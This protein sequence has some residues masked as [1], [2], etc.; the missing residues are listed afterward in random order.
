VRES[1]DS[2]FGVVFQSA[3]PFWPT[4]HEVQLSKDGSV[5][6]P[7]R[8]EVTCVG[9]NCVPFRDSCRR[10]VFTH[11]D[12]PCAWRSLG[13]AEQVKGVFDGRDCFWSVERKTNRKD[14]VKPLRPIEKMGP[15][16][17]SRVIYRVDDRS[18]LH[19]SSVSSCKWQSIQRLVGML[20][21][22]MANSEL[23][24]EYET[25]RLACAW[26]LGGDDDDDDD[27]FQ[28][29]FHFHDNKRPWTVNVHGLELAREWRT[30]KFYTNT[31]VV[32]RRCTDADV[33]ALSA[34]IRRHIGPSHTQS[35]TEFVEER[36]SKK[37]QAHRKEKWAKYSFSA[38]ELHQRLS[39]AGAKLEGLGGGDFA[40]LRGWMPK[41]NERAGWERREFER[42]TGKAPQPH[43]CSVS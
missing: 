19:P 6:L 5:E 34:E 8:M 1:A 28:G 20:P 29:N 16:A 12:D 27:G 17:Y 15:P 32:G 36:K 13:A 3:T 43:K 40:S 11:Q 39:L 26:T 37:A 25:P 21:T 31:N 23:R 14:E 33:E 2:G 42:W 10:V 18:L 4:V 35:Y 9:I 22:A 24:V 41:E 7:A 38:G 30:C